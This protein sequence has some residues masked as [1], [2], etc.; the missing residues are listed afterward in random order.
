MNYKESLV[1]FLVLDFLKEQDTKQCLYSIRE[2]VKFDDYQI[3]YLH[4][5]KDA[6]YPYELFKCGLIDKFIQ[7]KKNNGLGIGTKELFNS[8]FSEY[9]F[10][11]QNDQI[12]GR[13]FVEHELNELISSL[14]I[15]DNP[16]IRSIGLAGNICGYGIYS[17]RAHFIKTEF[18]KEMEKHI[19]LGFHGAGPYHDG[20]WREGQIQKFYEEMDY[21][22]MLWKQMVIDNGKQA[23][24]ENPDGSQWKHLPDTKELFLMKGPIKEKFVYP[25]FTDEEW[26]DVIKTQSWPEWK[27]P[28]NEEK[29]SFT[30]WRAKY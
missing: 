15:R 18:Y 10:Y 21:T 27:I 28:K 6:E 7:T 8:C 24:R 25:K 29:D 3:I 11:L 9:A 4:N 16:R 2:R 30:V 1:S 19:P 20:Q 22:H 12:L 14:N 26:N 5:G 17:E 23:I 13:D